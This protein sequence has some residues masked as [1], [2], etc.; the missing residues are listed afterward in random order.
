[1]QFSCV[2]CVLNVAFSSSEAEA[3]EKQIDTRGTWGRTVK[4]GATGLE[5]EFYLMQDEKL[6][7][8]RF[9]ELPADLVEAVRQDRIAI[10]NMEKEVNKIPNMRYKKQSTEND[11]AKPTKL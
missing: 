9:W 10:S 3:A 11:N 6:P 2:F 5:G 8:S 4:I 1:M 7:G